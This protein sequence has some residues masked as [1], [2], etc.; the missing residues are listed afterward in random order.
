M[1]GRLP[2]MPWFMLGAGCFGVFAASCS[3]TTRAPFLIDMARDLAVS[4][5]LVANLVAI[6]S[7]AWGVASLLAGTGSDRWGR[8]PFLIGGPFAMAISMLGVAQAESFLWV[9]VWATLGGGCSGMFTGVIYAEV[10]ARVGDRQR[11]RA[12][13]WVMSGQ[14]LTLVLGV[15]GAAYL[16]A[17]VG[18]RGVNVVVAGL[19]LVAAGLLLVSSRNPPDGRHAG[20]RAAT[21]VR[22]AMTGPVIRLLAMGIG[23]RVCY[24]L[25]A[26]YYATFLQTTYELTLAA[27]AL[28]LA[29]FALGNII[30]TVIGGQ[31]ADRLPNRRRTFAVATLGSGALALALFGWT[32]DMPTSVAFGFLYVMCNAIGR[33]ALMASLADVPDA[34]R[35]TVM[36]L[37]VT[38]ASVGWLS[39]AGL[40]GI[41]MANSGFGGF[42][43][44]TA[45]FAVATAAVALWGRR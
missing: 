31:L 2:G 33:P 37:N 19:G 3:G 21:G 16:G 25:P 43:P 17:S 14:S 12:L 40:G 1:S 30:G 32:P 8:R 23:E 18:W 13:G 5:P 42:G 26:V 4:V 6:T 35:G 10:S 28:P 9:V 11:G 44:L 15:P 24:G 27:V 34:V 29:I 38:G 39:A 7:I 20:G 36:G 45:G 22:A 41:I